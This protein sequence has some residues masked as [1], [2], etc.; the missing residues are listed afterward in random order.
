MAAENGLT[1]CLRILLEYV[2]ITNDLQ[3]II[4]FIVS[5]SGDADP[6]INDSFKM[7]PLHNA[8]ENNHKDC[9]K[10]ILNHRKGLSGLKLAASLADKNGR[11]DIAHIIRESMQR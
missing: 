11:A 4:I 2:N 6:T 1:E 7:L 3:N 9:V 8:V 5:I 10:C